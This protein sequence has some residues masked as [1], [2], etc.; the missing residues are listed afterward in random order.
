[1]IYIEPY[2]FTYGGQ[3]FIDKVGPILSFILVLIGVGCYKFI[4]R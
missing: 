1:M 3:L 4:K 2:I